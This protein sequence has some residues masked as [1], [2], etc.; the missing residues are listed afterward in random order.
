MN[1]KIKEIA[2][3]GIFSAMA[4]AGG[5]LLLPLHNIEIITAIIFLSGILFGER[6]GVFVGVIASSL[7]ATLNPF[8]IS[9]PPLFVAQ[10][11]SRALVGYVGGRFGKLS[12]INR[13]FWITAIYF[14]IAGLLLTWFY[15]ILTLFSAL[16]LSGF[17]FNQLKVTFAVGVVSYLIL[18]IGNTLIFATVLPL[19]VQRLQKSEFLKQ[20]N[21]I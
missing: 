19:V 17:S 1:I 12:F 18:A 10:V 16:F 21:L 5:Y 2:A 7:Y 13:K 15:N 8:G 11:V 6:N 4:F 20:A 14:G 3:V 9:P